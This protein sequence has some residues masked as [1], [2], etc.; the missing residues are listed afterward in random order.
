MKTAVIIRTGLGIRNRSQKEV[1]RAAG[2]NYFRLSLFLNRHIDL[3]PADIEKALNELDL[4]EKILTSIEI[5]R[6]Q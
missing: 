2:V 4:P 1:A 6:P 3:L 5:S